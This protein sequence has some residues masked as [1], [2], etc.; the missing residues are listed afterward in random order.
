M[1]I[2]KPL[3]GWKGNVCTFNYISKDFWNTA[4]DLGPSCMVFVNLEL[5]KVV[6]K[7]KHP[8]VL[9]YTDYIAHDDYISCLQGGAIV[10]LYREKPGV[11]TFP[12]SVKRLKKAKEKLES[13][14]IKVKYF[15]SRRTAEN[16][17]FKLN[18]KE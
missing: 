3:T 14:G 2:S 10:V 11:T 17:I 15:A 13:K 4:I 6:L 7:K 8:V 1:R 16:Y 12:A 5:I 9:T 18:V